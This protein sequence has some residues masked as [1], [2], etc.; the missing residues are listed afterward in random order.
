MFHKLAKL[1][2]RTVSL[3]V[4]IIVYAVTMLLLAFGV[5]G[6]VGLYLRLAKFVRFGGSPIATFWWILGFFALCF[7]VWGKGRDVYW[8]LYL[9][10]IILPI[11]RWARRN[12][13]VYIIPLSN[14]PWIERK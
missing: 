8:N 2:V 5:F 1:M 12:L 14:W 3:L 9:N 4:A 6:P 11:D 7:F 13:P 10:N